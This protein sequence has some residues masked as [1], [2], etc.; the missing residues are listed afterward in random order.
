[1]SIRFINFI[2]LHILMMCHM[3]NND[4]RSNVDST[5]QRNK[6][7]MLTPTRAMHFFTVFFFCKLHYVFACPNLQRTP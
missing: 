5:C 7:T 4:S 2:I 6:P 3:Y 1:M